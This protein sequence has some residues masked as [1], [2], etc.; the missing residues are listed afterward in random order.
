MLR[1]VFSS[2]FLAIWIKTS[3]PKNGLEKFLFGTNIR[4]WIFLVYFT[5]EL[6]CFSCREKISDKATR[7]FHEKKKME[8]NQITWRSTSVFQCSHSFILSLFFNFI[9][10]D[11]L[12]HR[13]A[14]RNFRFRFQLIH[15]HANIE[16]RMWN[17]IEKKVAFVALKKS[18]TDKKGAVIWTKEVTED[19]SHI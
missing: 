11:C 15:S 16:S 3:F 19:K 8:K 10:F 9:E 12:C 7:K 18:G 4:K 6:D 2:I 13:F 14:G 1:T 17:E 5:T